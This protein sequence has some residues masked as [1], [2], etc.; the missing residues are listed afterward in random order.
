MRRLWRLTKARGYAYAKMEYVSVRTYLSKI[1]Y[2]YD[3]FRTLNSIHPDLG[4]SEMYV[5]TSL[6][7]CSSRRPMTRWK[8]ITSRNLIIPFCTTKSDSKLIIKVAKNQFAVSAVI[9][10]LRIL[11]LFMYAKI[12]YVSVRTYHSENRIRTL[13]I[14]EPWFTR[15]LK[16]SSI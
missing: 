16:C 5:Y 11:F 15:L 7:Q 12:E 14:L 10:C 13:R 6:L 1:E 2:A 4:L 8:K 3:T 9:V